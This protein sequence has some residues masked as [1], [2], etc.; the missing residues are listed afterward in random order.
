M[1]LQP[2][3]LCLGFPC[4]RIPLLLYDA[5]QLLLQNFSAHLLW[6]S[7]LQCKQVF[8]YGRL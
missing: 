7:L 6:I 2:K 3:H 5:L 4:R 1:L 8:I